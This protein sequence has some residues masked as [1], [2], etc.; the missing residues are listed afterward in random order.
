[1][2]ALKD[3]AVLS[4]RPL[5]ALAASAKIPVEIMNHVVTR[6]IS[7]FRSEERF[8]D[9]PEEDGKSVGWHQPTTAAGWVVA[10]ERGGCR[11]GVSF[12]PAPNRPKKQEPLA[13][14]CRAGPRDDAPPDRRERASPPRQPLEQGLVAA[15][16]TTHA[17][18]P[19]WRPRWGRWPDPPRGGRAAWHV[20]V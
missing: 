6:Y 12:Q 14:E 9:G 8:S 3:L 17:R 11:K 2:V 4:K 10:N 16:D 18:P 19:R 7:A 20:L 1:M 15:P 13:D 5:H